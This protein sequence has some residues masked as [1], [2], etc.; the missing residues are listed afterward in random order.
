MRAKIGAIFLVLIAGQSATG[1]AVYAG[2]GTA[3]CAQFAEVYKLS[4][5][6]TETRFYT[7]AQGFMSA[8]NA[9]APAAAADAVDISDGPRHN[10]LPAIGGPETMLV[11]SAR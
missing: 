10:G 1:Q 5:S 2:V 8:L 11:Q 4:P 6:E 7:W 9:P 3:T